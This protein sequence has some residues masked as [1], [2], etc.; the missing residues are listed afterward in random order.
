MSAQ[1]DGS[2][3][4]VGGY[5]GRPNAADLVSVKV[6]ATDRGTRLLLLTRLLA[7]LNDSAGSSDLGDDLRAGL[8]ADL[9][10]KLRS[11]PLS[12]ALDFAATDCGIS[13]VIDAGL[14]RQR[15]ARMERDQSDRVVFEHFIR[16]SASPQLMG[17]LF[18]VS[19][20]D[21]RRARKL[22][23]PETATGGRPRQAHEALRSKIVSAWREL[24]VGGHGE[25]DR[26]HMLSKLFPELEIVALEAVI[27]PEVARTSAH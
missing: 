12:D 24:L 2:D 7:S 6:S 23:A 10:D 11:L 26:Y 20:A 21:V 17:R 22:I 16:R 4:P 13:I 19:Q 8:S 18:S 14:I 9:V 15:L 25:R 3:L 1:R 27:E 5:S